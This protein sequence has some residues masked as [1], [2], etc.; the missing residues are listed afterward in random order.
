MTDE[1]D[2][3]MD[4]NLIWAYVGIG[5]DTVHARGLYHSLREALKGYREEIPNKGHLYYCKVLDTEGNLIRTI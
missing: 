1:L 3:R 2:K 5:D 4:L